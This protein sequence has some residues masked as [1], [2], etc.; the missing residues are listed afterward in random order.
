MDA[1]LKEKPSMD[2][3]DLEANPTGKPEAE[4]PAGADAKVRKT[5]AG[6]HL[7]YTIAFAFVLGFPFVVPFGHGL[8]VSHVSCRLSLYEFAVQ[9]VHRAEEA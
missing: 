6:L 3:H 8:F 9:Y 5:Y 7:R 4:G 1:L 2:Q